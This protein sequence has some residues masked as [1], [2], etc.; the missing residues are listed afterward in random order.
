MRLDHDYGSSL[1]K[2]VTTQTGDTVQPTTHV[3]SPSKESSDR[4]DTTHPTIHVSSPLKEAS[5]SGQSDS[6]VDS[7]P[8]SSDPPY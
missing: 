5:D 6:D 1:I 8:S 2:K 7:L 4:V 3:S